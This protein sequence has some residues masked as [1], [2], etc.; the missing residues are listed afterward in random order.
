M[1]SFI[2][3]IKFKL[4]SAKLQSEIAEIKSLKHKL[5]FNT[6]QGLRHGD[7][8]PE[9]KQTENNVRVGQGCGAAPHAGRCRIPVSFDI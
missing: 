5:N 8:L 1:I 3:I 4:K 9:G 7:D 6:Q 2:V